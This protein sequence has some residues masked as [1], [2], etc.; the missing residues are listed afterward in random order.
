MTLMVP[1]AAWNVVST[2]F[3]FI[4]FCFLGGVGER[5]WRVVDFVET[6]MWARFVWCFPCEAE[7]RSTAH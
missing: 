5:C 1:A 7:A 2:Q 6:N 4:S 3:R